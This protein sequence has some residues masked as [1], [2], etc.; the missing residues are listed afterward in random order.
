M[1]VLASFFSLTQELGNETNYKYTEQ[2]IVVFNTSTHVVLVL[3]L[4]ILNNSLPTEKLVNVYST[5]CFR[6]VNMGTYIF[7]NTV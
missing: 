6:K 2:N 5:H 4:L 1:K 7:T 3:S